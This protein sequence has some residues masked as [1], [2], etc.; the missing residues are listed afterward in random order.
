MG[1]WGKEKNFEP[2]LNNIQKN[3]IFED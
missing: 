3:L 2:A 1:V